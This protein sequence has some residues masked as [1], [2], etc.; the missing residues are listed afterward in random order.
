VKTIQII[1]DTNGQSRLETQGFTGSS[2]R[3]ASKQL[4][5]ALG[6]VQSDTPTAEL[7]QSVTD[8]QPLR[9]TNGK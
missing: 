1:I 5:Q 4:E 2:C 9:Q 7:Y 8:Q 6:I 3:E